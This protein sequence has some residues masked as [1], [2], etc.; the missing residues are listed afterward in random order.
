MTKKEYTLEIGGKTIVA[1]FSDFVDQSNAVFMSCGD[2]IV[3]VTAVMSK[4]KSNTDFFNLTVDY[5][6]K[7][8]AS[9]KLVG[10]GS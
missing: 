2:T 10:G 8:Y 7:F 6:E 5:M 1:T 3:L 9:G 4:E